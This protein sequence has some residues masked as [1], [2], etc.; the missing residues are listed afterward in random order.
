[1]TSNRAVLR[2]IAATVGPLP[3]A[4]EALVD[5]EADRHALRFVAGPILSLGH[6]DGPRVFVAALAADSAVPNDARAAARARLRGWVGHHAPT[7][8]PF[9]EAAPAAA[10]RMLD[11]PLTGGPGELYLDDLQDV[12]HHL[13]AGALPAPAKVPLLGLAMSLRSGRVTALTRHGAFDAARPYLRAAEPGLEARAAD[14]RH[15]GLDGLWALR[16]GD[17]GLVGALSVNEARWRGDIE[18]A[19]R[20]ARQLAADHGATD[21]WEASRA[22]ARDVGLDIVPDAIELRG[23]GGMDLTLALVDPRAP[24]RRGGISTGG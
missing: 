7:A 24:G 15:A 13:S 6:D 2:W 16:W 8:L 9:E 11:V 22:T 18:G 10:R 21:A 23:D 20:A 3:P 4:L 14:L 1:M 19:Q 5:P 12:P 17:T